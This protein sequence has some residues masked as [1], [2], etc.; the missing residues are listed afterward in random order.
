MH[1][2][3]CFI[4]LTFNAENLDPSGSLNKADFQLFMKRL[5][6][7]FFGNLK[8]N[9]RYFHCGEY[10]ED[11]E[12]LKQNIK[13]LG[14]PHHH[15]CLFGFDFSDKI[16]WKNKN[17]VKLYTSKTL[18]NLWPYGFSTIGAVTF[19]SAAY[20]ARYIVKKINGDMAE[21]HY[22][23]KTPEYTTMSRRPGIASTWFD[24]YGSE[25]YPRDFV[26]SRGF[27]AK[28]PKYYD[29][30]YDLTN[31]EESRILLNM[32]KDS[33]KNS[34]DNTPRRLADRGVVARAR[35]KTLVRDLE[36]QTGE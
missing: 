14:R 25:V 5:R 11:Q 13:K 31:P 20:V 12:A 8:S 7:H 29:K 33:A 9:I 4:T 36:T 19:E 26:T 27:K 3:N 21:K 10:G 32:R 1:E 24:K 17:G 23:G 34:P 18:E 30:I 35:A 15:A 2:N 22:N 16:L 6:K 28:P